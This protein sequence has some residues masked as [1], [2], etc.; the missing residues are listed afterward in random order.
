MRGKKGLSGVVTTLLIVLLVLAAVGI[1]WNPIKNLLTQ[2][3]DEFDQTKCLNI[4]VNLKKIGGDGLTGIYNVTLQRTTTGTEGE[5]G[6]KIIFFSDESSS[7]LIDFGEKLTPLELRIQSID[8]G[9]INATKMQVTLYL[10]D[11]ATGKEKLCKG[12]KE[13]SFNV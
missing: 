13:I 7:E 6:V 8:S 3:S 4:D 2:S 11:S 10:I 12:S 5:V 9:I 1:I